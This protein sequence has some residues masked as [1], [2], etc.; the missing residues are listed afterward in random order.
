MNERDLEFLRR[1]ISLAHDAREHGNHPFGALI[2]DGAGTIVAEAEN[3]VSTDQDPTGHAE[4][5]A[6]RRAG[7]RLAPEAWS[8]A[9]LYTSCEP[10]AMCSGAIFWAGIGRVV[11]GL[12]NDA[13]VAMLPDG[14]DAPA[15][16]LRS[17]EVIDSG[18]RRIAVEGPVLEDEAVEP[19]REFW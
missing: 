8:E 15:L 3:S 7:P 1:A 4:T 10:C 12:S 6:V 13:L 18:N 17:A 9:T 2:V 16:G 5:N 14:S 11:F 19:H